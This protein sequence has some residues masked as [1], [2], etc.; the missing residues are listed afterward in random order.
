MNK[1][2]IDI[3]PIYKLG[4]KITLS[5]CKGYPSNTK[6]DL[7][8]LIN[9]SLKLQL[10]KASIFSP[11]K[12]CLPSIKLWKQAQPNSLAVKWS[13]LFQGIKILLILLT[14]H[15]LFHLFMFRQYFGWA[16]PSKYYIAHICMMGILC[17]YL[18]F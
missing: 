10:F 14:L 18:P 1:E 8:Y 13:D 7:S 15:G 16:Q 9:K 4:S 3:C 5:K 11:D 12:R 2:N 6:S 17:K